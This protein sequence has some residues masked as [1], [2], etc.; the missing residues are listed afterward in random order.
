MTINFINAD[1]PAPECIFAGT[2]TRPGGNSISPF[3]SFN[4]ASHVNDDLKM[5]V[6]NRKLLVTELD[7]PHEPIWLNQIHSTTVLDYNKLNSTNN[8]ENCAD[9][10][11]SFDTNKICAV[12]TADCVPVLITDTMG[13]RVAAIHAG[14]RGLRDGIIEKTI[15]ALD[16][17]PEK[18]L[19]WIGPAISS[20]VFEVDDN[21]RNEFIHK[22]K[23][24]VKAYKQSRLGHWYMDLVMLVKQ[25]LNKLNI[26]NNAIYGGNHCSYLENDLFYS[27]RR[28]NVTGRMASLIYIRN[29]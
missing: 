29:L 23:T 24:A 13:S 19:V 7:L 26:S 3:D 9:A 16:L 5:V 15:I 27:Y 18:L 12:L 1:W 10:I 25:R 22:D 8:E 6:K 20:S 28:N 14:W 11:I 2:T 21:V 4:L 17:T